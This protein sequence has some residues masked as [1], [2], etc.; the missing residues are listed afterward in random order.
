MPTVHVG[1][2][3]IYYESHG[4]GEPLLLIMGY[5]QYSALWAPLIRDLSPEYRVI[6]FDNRGTGRS[7]KPDIPYTMKVMADDAKGLLDAIGI[8]L[9]HVFGMSM[10]G[11]I[12]Q[13]FALNYPGKLKSL[14]LGCTHYGGTKMVMPSQEALAFLLGP[15]TAKLPV[16]ERARQTVRWLWT[17]EYIDNNPR[18]VELFVAVTTEYPTPLHGYRCQAKA[19]MGHDTYDRLPRITTPTLVISGDA[20]RLI[21]AENSRILSSRIPNAELVILENSGHGF[22]TDAREKATGAILDFLRRHSKGKKAT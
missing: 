8:D 7:D 16:E 13:E 2:I 6:S 15:E 10:G 18:A 21:P 12:A 19:I 1:D 4:D 3:N 9:A 5:G 20:D 17:Q 14:I 22:I 11:M